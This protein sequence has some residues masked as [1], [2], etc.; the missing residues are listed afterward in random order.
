MNSFLKCKI[1]KA[2]SICTYDILYMNWV[3]V[4]LDIILSDITPLNNLLLD[5]NFNKFTVGLH[6]IHILFMLA[7]FYDDQRLIVMVSINCLNSS[8]CSLK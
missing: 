1:T 6:Y 5:V 8:F 2:K 7:K 4:T 3:Q